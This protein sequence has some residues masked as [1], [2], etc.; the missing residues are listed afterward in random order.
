MVHSQLANLNLNDGQ[1]NS[2]SSKLDAS[3]QALALGNNTA[4]IQQLGAFVNELDAFRK[5]GLVDAAT[6][7]FLDGE[8]Q[9]AIDLVH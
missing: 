8:I 7:D 5:S 2:L 9:T 6:A 4:A 3:Q 1:I